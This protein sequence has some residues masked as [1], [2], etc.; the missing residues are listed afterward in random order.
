MVKIRGLKLNDK[1]KR[2]AYK[3]IVFH[4]EDLLEYLD[5]YDTLKIKHMSFDLA[6]RRARITSMIL[7][8]AGEVL[9]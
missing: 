1:D 5:K 2:L 7:A 8:N 3:S 9:S 6:M 4:L